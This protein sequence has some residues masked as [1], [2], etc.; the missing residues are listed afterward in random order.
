ML[1]QGHGL[2][3]HRVSPP[4]SPA[5]QNRFHQPLLTF[6]HITGHAI[7]RSLVLLHALIVGHQRGL[8]KIYVGQHARGSIWRR[9]GLA[10]DCQV[11]SI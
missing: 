5:S 3:L 6:S 7:Q 10:D 2:L 1:E 8:A 4:Q 11:H 9:L